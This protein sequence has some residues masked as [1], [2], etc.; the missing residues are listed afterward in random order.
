VR[1]R[2]RVELQRFK[3]QQEAEEQRRREEAERPIREAEAKLTETIRQLHSNA[4]E[5]VM[6]G[7]PDPGFK[8]PASVAGKQMSLEEARRFN[9]AESEKFRAVHPEYYPCAANFKTMTNYLATQKIAIVDAATWEAAF[10]RLQSLGLL[11]ERPEAE[12]ASESQQG[13]SE[14]QAET[15]ST[16]S[17]E[18]N[19]NDYFSKVVATDP[20]TGEGL[21]E[22]QL[23]QLP[24]SEYARI[25]RVPRFDGFLSPTRPV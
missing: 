14:P 3:K 10:S 25:M 23:D 13:R 18:Q 8:L 20:R 6:S 7:Q 12:P 15:V 9:A 17:A 1:E 16:E 2:D 11:Q 4:K 5:A 22:H 21:T 24:S 19:R